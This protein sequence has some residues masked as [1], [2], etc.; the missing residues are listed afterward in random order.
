MQ[1]KDMVNDILAQLNSS[2]TTYTSAIAQCST[3]TVRQTLQ[4]IRN[5]C[6]TSQ[7][8]LYQLASQKG[9]YKPAAPADT[10]DIQT[11]KSTF[12]STNA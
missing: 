6:E 9:Y 1:D 2:L 8:D 4:Q 12:N 7:W 5:N 11:I 10:A 3:A